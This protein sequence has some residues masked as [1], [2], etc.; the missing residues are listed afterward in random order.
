[1]IK[2]ILIGLGSVGLAYKS[3]NH[4][5]ARYKI[6]RNHLE[7]LQS[8]TG[9]KITGLVEKDHK[10]KLFLKKDLSNLFHSN[11]SSLSNN[12]IDLAVVA[13]STESH[14]NILK[15]LIRL[16][17]P[18]ILVE[19][20]ITSNLRQAL[21]IEKL[22]KKY[23]TKIF[24]NFNRRYDP[25]FLKIKEKYKEKPKLIIFRYSKGLYNY[26]SHF[27]DLIIYWYGKI[28]KVKSTEII[29]KKLKKDANINFSM[30]TKNN[31]EIKCIATNGLQYDQ[32]EI[33][34][35][36]KK[37]ILSIK[38]GGNDIFK[39]KAVKNLYFSGYTQIAE[40]KKIFSSTVGNLLP[41]YKML[42]NGIKKNQPVNCCKIDEALHGIKVLDAVKKSYTKNN[43]TILIK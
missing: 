7:A 40:S 14:Y 3:N 23:K 20:P 24:I 2:T 13:C 32:F 21:T 8:T 12:K 29:K 27:V 26:G 25:I 33:D 39:A 43:K 28:I 18:Y 5:S 41:L 6:I 38:N 15:S 10:K 1:M 22:I 36:Y 37:F 11:L 9:Y 16:R 30:I 17:V 42:R 35:F 31:I 4:K 19:K 34:F